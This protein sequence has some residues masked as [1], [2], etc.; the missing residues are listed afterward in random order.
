MTNEVFYKKLVKTNHQIRNWDTQ[1]CLRLLCTHREPIF[2]KYHCTQTSFAFEFEKDYAQIKQG[3]SSF[4]EQLSSASPPVHLFF[5]TF[6]TSVFF[7]S[8]LVLSAFLF[9]TFLPTCF[10]NGSF[11]FVMDF[12]FFVCISFLCSSLLFLGFDVK[13]AA[14]STLRPLELD[15]GNFGPGD[16]TCMISRTLTVAAVIGAAPEK[17]TKNLNKCVVTSSPTKNTCLRYLYGL[18]LQLLQLAVATI[19]ASYGLGVDDRLLNVVPV[20]VLSP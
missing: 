6:L 4:S 17:V 1:K 16:T 7:K 10:V 12:C 14:L 11:V 13:C 18:E 19:P 20:V 15:A 5:F 2:G 8:V 9:C 3:Y